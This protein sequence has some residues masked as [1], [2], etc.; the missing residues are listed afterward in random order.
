MPKYF[1]DSTFSSVCPC[2][3]R[4]DMYAWP[5]AMIVFCFGFCVTQYVSIQ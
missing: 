2:N 5:W 4:I 1:A 3:C